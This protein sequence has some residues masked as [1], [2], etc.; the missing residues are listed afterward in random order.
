MCADWNGIKWF[1]LLFWLVQKSPNSCPILET[2]QKSE[3]TL[4]FGTVKY[5]EVR[6]AET[7]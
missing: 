3:V 6:C 1:S 4:Y 2:S 5:L 7:N